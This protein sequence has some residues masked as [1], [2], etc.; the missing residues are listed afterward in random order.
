MKKWLFFRRFFMFLIFGASIFMSVGY[1]VIN[2]VTLDITGMVSVAEN[3][4][5]KITNVSYIAS[6][7]QNLSKVST[8]TWTDD[9]VNFDITINPRTRNDVENKEYIATYEVTIVNDS[10][11]DHAVTSTN[12]NPTVASGDSNNITVTYSL[13]TEDGQVGL[14]SE[15]PAKST[16]KFYVV[17]NLYPTYT[18]TF[19]VTGSSEVGTEEKDDGNFLGTIPSG[20]SGDVRGN[21]TTAKFTATI[22][23]SYKDSK[24]YTL[25]IVNDSFEIVDENGNAFGTLTIGGNETINVDFYIRRKVGV[26]FAVDE[27]NMNVYFEEVGVSRN[28]MGIVKMLVDKDETI[29]DYDAP[30]ISGVAAAF[31]SEVGTVDLSWQGTDDVAGVDYYTVEVYK[32]S[33]NTSS[34]VGEARNTTADETQM[35]ITGLEDNVTYFFKVYGTD[36]TGKTATAEEISSCSTDAGTCSRSSNVSYDWHFTV[37]FRLTNASSSEGNSVAVDYMGTVSTTLSGTGNYSRPNSITSVKKSSGGNVGTSSSTT[38]PYYVYN[39][40]NGSFSIYNVNEDITVTA[41]GYGGG[42]FAKGTKILLANGKYKN[43]EDI[44]YDDLLAVWNY[45]TGKITYEYPLWIENEHESSSIIRVSFSDGT[46]ID[47]VNNHA[48]YSTDIN[49]FVDINDSDNFH[50]GT[51]VAKINNGKFKEVTVS[52]IEYINKQVK[53]YFVGTTTYYNVIAN[54][55][56]TTDENLLI[57]NLY[58]FEDGAKWPNLKEKVVNNSENLL[59]YSYFSDVLPLYL[60]K[61]FRVREAGFLVNSGMTNLESFKEYITK[62]IINPYMIKKPISKNGYNYWMVTT[63]KDKVIDSNKKKYLHKEGTYYQLPKKKGVKYWYLTSDNKM[64][65]PG[66]KVKIYHGMHFV[67]N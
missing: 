57:S 56:L 26:K 41:S 34:M 44:G 9:S 64:Y 28:S 23:N 19:N 52:N 38:D 40:S 13:E 39:S 50:V 49:L 55:I 32:V 53:F 37:T 27:V 42:C 4:D 45:D 3:G 43:V 6:R 29:H 20:L 15:I 16:M 66:D 30:T 12:F 58:G 11:Y 47:F 5:I 21:V 61:G 33:G 22:L 67:A 8:P 10:L 25:S 36:L 18:G 48:I 14:N 63:S 51:H 31:N 46:S 2:N 35:Q 54:S 60:Y 7:S 17:I 65:K 24:N 62:L 1:A 59:D